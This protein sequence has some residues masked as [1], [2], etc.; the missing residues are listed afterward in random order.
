MVLV[1]F[2]VHGHHAPYVRDLAQG[3]Y[4]LGIKVT[5]I[6]P[7]ELQ[8]AGLGRFLVLEDCE[9][10]NSL[11]GLRRQ[12]AAF[13]VCRRALARARDVKPTHI[14][15]LYADF[16]VSSIAMAW[17][18]SRPEANPVLT[19]HWI[20]GVGAGSAGVRNWFRRIPHR[21]ALRWFARQKGMR[22]LVHH[23][24]VAKSISRVIQPDK[25]GVIPYP[26]Q[27][28]PEVEMES[29]LNF[30]KSL[31][32]G[33]GDKLILC[34]GGTRFDKGADLAVKALARL[35]D[36]FHLL[37]AGRPLYFGTDCLRRQ[38]RDL[39]VDNRLHLLMKFL[40]DE[41]TALVFYACDVVLFPYRKIFSG[42][43]GP[44]TQAA[45]I[46]KVAVV[47]DLS[48]LR[49]TVREYRLGRVFP[50]GDIEKM[51]EAL[52]AAVE[53]NVQQKNVDSFIADHSPKA[54][55]QA[56]YANYHF[57]SENRG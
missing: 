27:P 9:R 4:D 49:K 14:H 7:P 22:I 28:M 36:N 31:G 53:C 1:D 32:V 6:G 16:H 50:A 37:A 40:S 55:A 57:V 8:E 15:F 2:Y 29:R 19:V 18:F 34:Y 30:R 42:Q 54:F 13:P 43:S 35:A 46:G 33:S 52:R 44:L 56:V 51:T 48:V 25:I 24:T 17:R 3:L 47:A 21:A 38:A 5:V 26:N 41:E 10:L 20:K 23:D 12:L 45:S 39:G 11:D